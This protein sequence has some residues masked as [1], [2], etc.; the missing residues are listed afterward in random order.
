MPFNSYYTRIRNKERREAIKKCLLEGIEINENNKDQFYFQIWALCLKKD[1]F[2]HNIHVFNKKT[3]K[4]LGC[5][6]LCKP[7][8]PLT[9][10]LI[11]GEEGQIITCKKC[12]KIYKEKVIEFRK[13][14]ETKLI[15][16][17]AFSKSIQKLDI[18]L[19]KEIEKIESGAP[20]L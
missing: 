20:A 14:I 15:E 18:L 11:G 17:P 1:V 2:H 3:D 19:K 8:E 9:N 13:V 12:I 7:Y 16:M 10:E 6:K 4:F 5:R